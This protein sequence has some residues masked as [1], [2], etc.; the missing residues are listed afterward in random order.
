MDLVHHADISVVI[1]DNK[2]V[3]FEG[4]KHKAT[5]IY[6]KF[7]IMSRKHYKTIASALNRTKPSKAATNKTHVWEMVVCEMVKTFSKANPNFDST[8]F[9]T[10]CGFEG[11]CED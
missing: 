11:D 3:I 2:R 6:I 1:D 10:V 4:P 9:L 5:E 8:Q 7:S